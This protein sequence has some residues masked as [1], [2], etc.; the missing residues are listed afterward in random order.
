LEIENGN[1]VDLS[2]ILQPL[3]DRIDALEDEVE[4]CCGVVFIN[5][6][7]TES[8]AQLFQNYPNP[9]DE[10]TIIEFYIPRGSYTSAYLEVYSM[11]GS[12][13]SKMQVS[14]SGQ[15]QVVLGKNLLSAGT[16]IYTLVADNTIID[17]KQM[18]ISH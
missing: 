1:S 5:E 10:S 11:D 14:P 17:T 6:P 16:Y 2:P 12:L 18:I 8:Q 3:L 4:I 13:V 7:G 9:F 15:G